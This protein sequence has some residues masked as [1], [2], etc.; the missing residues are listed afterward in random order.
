MDTMG[1]RVRVEAS[2]DTQD[3]LYDCAWSEEN[4]NHMCV[5]AAASRNSFLAWCRVSASGDGSVKLWDIAA[6]SPYPMKSYEEH[7]HEVY[8]VDW[9]L[10][11]KV[12]LLEPH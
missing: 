8:S 12:S 6:G 3:G 11:N 5:A 4:E 1:G 2:F 7:T 9:N 10:V